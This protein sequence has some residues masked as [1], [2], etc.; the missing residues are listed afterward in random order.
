MKLALNK[1]VRILRHRLVQTAIQLARAF[2]HRLMFGQKVPF[3]G[4]LTK[5]VSAW[6]QKNKK[7]D[8][9]VG[10][11]GWEAPY[12]IGKWDFLNQLEELAHYKRDNRLLAAS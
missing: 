3:A 1:K 4:E 12:L 6:E 10:Q 7:G 11:D 2:F 8:I 9:L 5:V